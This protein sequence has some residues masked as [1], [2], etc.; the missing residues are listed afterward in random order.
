MQISMMRFRAV[1][2]LLAGAW[3][4]LC[5]PIATAQTVL[6]VG[7]QMTG[8]LNW[9]LSYIKDRG[10][11]KAAG[12]DIVIVPMAT[13]EA[14]KIAIIGGAVDIVL[15]DWLWVA[16]ERSLGGSLTFSPYSSALGAVMV[17]ANS[18]IRSLADLSGKSVGVAGGPLDKSWLLLR[19]LAQREGLDLAAKARPAYAAPP[20]INQK[21]IA[22]ELDAAV[23][24]W[25]FCVP[26]QARGFRPLM[27][28]TEVEKALGARG[29][30]GIVGFVF[31]EELGAAKPELLKGFMTLARN[32][33]E[34]VAQDATA[35]SSIMEKL[36]VSDPA[37]R[38]MYRARYAAGLVRRPL[39]EEIADARLLFATLA[40]IGGT[41][42]VGNARELPPN[43]FYR[44]A[45]Q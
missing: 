27:E 23:Q 20:L 28:I 22:G 44:P 26:L 38:E 18:P 24:F 40:G 16:R 6:R 39:D 15:S 21:A 37:V 30:V 9:E 10:L 34:A 31:K 42:L 32:A 14:G 41:D 2:C 33:R 17:P 7:A 13:T 5:A 8:S 4:F 3:L 29:A 1:L 19:A 43:V 45:G 35:W 36:Q 11:D 25:N 12:L